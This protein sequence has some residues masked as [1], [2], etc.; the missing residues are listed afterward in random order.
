M[1]RSIPSRPRQMLPAPMTMAT[2]TPRS[3]TCSTLAATSSARWGSMPKP[4]SPERASPPSLS[5]MR[6][7]LG[8]ANLLAHLPAL[9]T[10]DLD[11]LVG[12][13]HHLLQHLGHLLV[14]VPHVFLAGEAGAVQE[15][16]QLAFHDPL[17]HRLRLSLRLGLLARLRPLG[18]QDLGR[19]LLRADPARGPGRHPQRRP[20]PEGPGG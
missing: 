9:K 6:R 10:P 1:P 17:D 3:F 20:A 7:Y 13:Q 2:C 4:R 11:I 12:G 16:L 14:L 8:S 5:R 15:F 19:N 18:V